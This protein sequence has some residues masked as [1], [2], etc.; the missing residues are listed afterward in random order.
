MPWGIYKHGKGYKVCLKRTKGECRSK[1]PISKEKAKKQIAA[2]E[3]NESFLE[4][5][6]RTS[7]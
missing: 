6:Y 4:F 2:I 5:V 3:M 7:K 1:Q